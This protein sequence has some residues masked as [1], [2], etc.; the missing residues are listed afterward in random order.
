M[1]ERGSGAQRQPELRARFRVRSQHPPAVWVGKRTGQRRD[2]PFGGVRAGRQARRRATRARARTTLGVDQTLRAPK[3]EPLLR[4]A[5]QIAVDDG[6]DVHRGLAGPDE[7][8]SSCRRYRSWAARWA[9]APPGPR[10]DAASARAPWA[11]FRRALQRRH[12]AESPRRWARDVRAASSPPVLRCPSAAARRC[13]AARVRASR[14]RTGD[15]R[16]RPRRALVPR[17]ARSPPAAPPGSRS[18]TPPEP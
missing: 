6:A 12:L 10:A 18:R 16:V 11:R 8:R 1:L 15:G 9:S 3:R 2:Y 5:L 13:V 14:R 7:L 4:D 17:A